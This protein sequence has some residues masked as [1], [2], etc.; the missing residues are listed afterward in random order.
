MIPLIPIIL[1]IAAQ[2]TLG[3]VYEDTNNGLKGEQR[4]DARDGMIN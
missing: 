3:V 2:V 4:R 1:F